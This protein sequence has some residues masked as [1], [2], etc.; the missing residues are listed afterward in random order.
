MLPPKELS[1]QCI[2]CGQALAPE[3]RI[4]PACGADREVELAVAAQ[5]G[6]AI[7]TLR[8]WLLVLGVLMLLPALL[9]YSELRSQ[10]ATE[11]FSSVVL[12]DLIGA[13]IL[14]ALSAV[15]R[16][17]PL[18]SSLAALVLFAASWG[19]A[20]ERNWV[21]ALSPS[22]PLVIRVIFLIV[23]IGAVQAGWKARRIRRQA[24]ASF[25][26]AVARTAK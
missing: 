3:E 23:L 14:F 5:L 20:I 12:P 18:G 13:G 7:S 26:S 22:L 19:Q 4:C 6:P 24:K 15:A 9:I 25:P 10:H 11:L 1:T 8:R 21:T 16:I 17:V 2:R